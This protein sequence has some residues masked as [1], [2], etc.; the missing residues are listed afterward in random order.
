LYWRG[1]LA[2]LVLPVALCPINA[3]RVVAQERDRMTFSHTQIMAQAL[4]A[5]HPAPHVKNAAMSLLLILLAL[6]L[7]SPALAHHPLGGAA[8]QTVAHGLISGLAHPVI[9]LDHLAFIVLIG[10]AAAFSGRA[11]AGPLA[12]IAATLAGT[13]LHL[14]GVMLPLAELVITA[15]VV[16]LGALVVLGRQVGGPVALAG[17]ALAGIFHGW[18]Y[19]EAV[20][21]STPMPI[22]AYLLGFGAVQFAIA[23]GVA[24]VAGKLVAQGAGQ[25]QARLAAAICT[26]IGFAFLFE[27]VESLILG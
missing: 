24:L 19:G 7:A 13:G 10:L 3:R 4:R 2:V 12:F 11:M 21:G 20:I 25:M 15:S 1:V 14:A 23:A 18:A 6:F 16:A 26:G 27:T 9:G 22:A 5:A 17:F 8:P